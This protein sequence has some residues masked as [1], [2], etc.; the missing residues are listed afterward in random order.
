MTPITTIHTNGCMSGNLASQSYSQWCRIKKI[1]SIMKRFF[2][3]HPIVLGALCNAGI[4]CFGTFVLS[5]YKGDSS[6]MKRILKGLVLGASCALIEN[7]AK[8]YHQRIKK[9]N[10]EN[11]LYRN[12]LKNRFLTTSAWRHFFSRL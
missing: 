4:F 11:S 10:I 5:G 6:V 12:N 1:D 9:E 2:S 8:R 3:S 7:V